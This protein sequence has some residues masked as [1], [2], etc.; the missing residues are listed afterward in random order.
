ME[1]K[2]FNELSYIPFAIAVGG[3]L[4]VLVGQGLSIYTVLMSGLLVAAGLATGFFSHRRIN[5]KIQQLVPQL[6]DQSEQSQTQEDQ[7]L[8]RMKHNFQQSTQIWL[9]QIEHLRNDG[10]A[11]VDELANQFTNVIS[12]LNTAMELFNKTISSRSQESGGDYR[13]WRPKCAIVSLP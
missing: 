10:Q 1:T 3:A 12:R 8:E 11:D 6:P 5:Q 4:S 9:D 7:L 13:K 2:T